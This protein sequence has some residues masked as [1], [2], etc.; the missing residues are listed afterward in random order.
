MSRYGPKVGDL[1][2]SSTNQQQLQDQISNC[3]K[4]LPGVPPQAFVNAI[5][6]VTV[7]DAFMK[8]FNDATLTEKQVI[9]IIGCI[10]I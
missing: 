2:G 6:K 4:V 3:S 1:L 10:I 8:S 7:D 5:K 9:Y